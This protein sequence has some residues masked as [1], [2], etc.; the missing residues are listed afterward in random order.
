MYRVVVDFTSLAF[1]ARRMPR[2]KRRRSALLRTILP[3]YHS[4]ELEVD[5]RVT[6]NISAMSS[7][8]AF[9]ALFFEPFTKL[10]YFLDLRKKE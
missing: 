1:R 3:F 6:F 7:L 2:C 4:I 5:V 10:L 9:F 8:V